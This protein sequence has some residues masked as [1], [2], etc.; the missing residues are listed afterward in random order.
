MK[1]N[2]EPKLI[3]FDKELHTVEIYNYELRKNDAQKLVDKF[4]NL[5]IGHYEDG[6]LKSLLG[7]TD[8]YLFEKTMALVPK[9]DMTVAGIKLNDKK[10]YEMIDKPIEYLELQEMAKSH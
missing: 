8:E 9:N 1:N 10:F 7:F 5:G 4:N 2:I 6:E 3:Y